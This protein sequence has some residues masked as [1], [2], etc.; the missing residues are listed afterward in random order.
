MKKLLFASSVFLI[1]LFVIA[2]NPKANKN[3]SEEEKNDPK[4]A[5]AT[6]PKAIEHNAPDQAK[7]DSVKAA[8]AKLRDK[9]TPETEEG[10]GN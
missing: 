10:G 2:C 3:M 8:K 9:V 4:E 7:I 6:S 1:A 5:E